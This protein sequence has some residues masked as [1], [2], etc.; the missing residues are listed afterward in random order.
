MDYGPIVLMCVSLSECFCC[1]HEKNR[2][3]RPGKSLFRQINLF[4]RLAV[5]I[6]KKNKKINNRTHKEYTNFKCAAVLPD[7]SV[8]VRSDGLETE[9]FLVNILSA[10]SLADS[11]E[12]KEHLISHRHHVIQCVCVCVTLCLLTRILK[13]AGHVK[14]WTKCVCVCVHFSQERSW[15]EAGWV[16]RG[17]RE[18]TRGGGRKGGSERWCSRSKNSA[19]S[20]PL[21]PPTLPSAIPPS[22]SSISSSS[23][24]LMKKRAAGARR[25]G[26]EVLLSSTRTSFL[27]RREERVRPRPTREQRRRRRRRRWRE[28]GRGETERLCMLA[29]KLFLFDVQAPNASS[30][31]VSAWCRKPLDLHSS[32]PKTGELVMCLQARS[33]KWP[34]AL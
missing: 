24:S 1:A 12:D 13:K 6:S 17:R 25:G 30:C 22:P 19:A 14:H 27:S 23:L 8:P 4:C 33:T 3:N 28:G 29:N 7:E 9:T 34:H 31:F 26:S 5:L 2:V 10:G 20:I 32:C 21:L 16:T 18:K 11:S 15:A